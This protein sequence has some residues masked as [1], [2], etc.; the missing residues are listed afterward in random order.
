MTFSFERWLG[1]ST[2]VGLN[3]FCQRNKDQNFSDLLEAKVVD[4]KRLQ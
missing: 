4:L 1:S 2:R 3:M